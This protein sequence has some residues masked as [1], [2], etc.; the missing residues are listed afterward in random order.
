MSKLD[1]TPILS[2][3]TITKDNLPTEIDFKSGIL[4]LIDKPLDWTSFDVVNKMRFKLKHKLGIK[5][6]KV[7]HAGTLDPL[8]TGLLLICAGKYT[9][10]IDTLSAMS[11]S[12][13]AEV[14]LGAVTASYDAECEEEQLADT[15]HIT[16]SMVEASLESF[17]GDISQ[18]PPIYSAIK[19]DGQKAYQA[20][21]KGEEIALKYRP[22]TISDLQLIS[23]DSPFASLDISC[24]K[25]TYIRSLAHDIGQSLGCGG[26]LAKLVRTSIDHYQ[27][28][29]ALTIDEAIEWIENTV[30]IPN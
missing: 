28:S 7:G 24:S 2:S 6:F 26:Y 9:K 3:H 17:R 5:K 16:Q 14:K 22:V 21:R 4:L 30:D 29:S 27:L 1:M 18:L 12:Y 25:G 20:A 15:K 23:F 10:S 11:K 13:L 19:V 8:A